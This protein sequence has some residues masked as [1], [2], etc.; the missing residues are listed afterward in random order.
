MLSAD[1]V[2]Q[3][4][5][6]GA[7][8]G[9]VLDRGNASAGSYAFELNDADGVTIANLGVTGGYDGIF[10]GNGSA[11][12]SLQN[13][14][15]FENA[16]SGLDITDAASSAPLI[17]DNVFYGDLDLGAS[18]DQDYGVFTRSLDPVVLR[19]RAY[20]ING[21][22]SYGIYLENA[23][24]NAIVRDNVLFNNSTR[25]LTLFGS[26]FEAT[27]NI[28]FN[29]GTGFYFDDTTAGLTAR[30]HDNVAHN[31][32]TGFELR[33]SAEYYNETA[34][35]NGT[36]FYTPSSAFDGSAHDLTSWRNTTGVNWGGGVLRD[37]RIFGNTGTGLYVTYGVWSLIG[38][39]IYENT[40]GIHSQGYHS[41]N[42]IANN[43]IYDN[44]T[45]G[46]LLEDVQ[47]S[48]GTLFVTN[49]TVMELASD[50]VQITGNSKN[51]QFKNN[52]LWSGGAG[53]YVL[54][55]ANTAQSG[56]SSDYNLLYFTSGA[57]L[58]YWQNDFLSLADW[59]YELG[60]DTHSLNNDPL[61]VDADGADNVRGYQ[62]FAGLKFEYFA[63]GTGSFG[64]S[65]AVT[66]FDGGVDFG[67]TFGS[68]RA[69]TG[70]PGDSQSFRWTGE[71]FLPAAGSYQ[72]WITSQG[73]QRLVI[74]GVNVIDDYGLTTSTGVEQTASYVAAAA[75]WVSIE[76]DVIDPVSGGPTMARLEW[77]TPD[78]AQRRV[79]RAVEAVPGVGERNV[80]RI[81]S[82]P[83]STGADD[84]FHLQSRFGSLKTGGA[85]TNDAAD[86]P[87]VDAGDPT[88]A[89]TGETAPNGGRI[90]L[91]FEGN[92][93]EA[94]HSSAQFI[95]LLSFTGGEKVRQ[96]QASL[97]RWRSTGL[98]P[99]DI[100]FSAN[101][102]S[103]W[104][105]LANDEVNDGIFAWNPAT[106]TL[107]GQLRV[108]DGSVADFNS[109][110]SVFD[111]S[112]ADFTV[113]VAGI[114]YYVND[115]VLA[116]DE[117]SSAAG[118]NANSGTTPSDPMVSLNAVLNVYD[119]GPG[120]II[121][122]DT[123]YYLLPTNVRVTAQ[124]SGVEI[125]GPTSNASAVTSYPGIINADAPL[126]YYRLDETSGTV[127]NDASGNAR[128]GAYVNG[129]LLSQPGAFSG[130]T[131]VRLDGTNDHVD[132]PD[133]FNSF[134]N[135]LT[136][137]F[138][139]YPTS[140]VGYHRFVELGVGQA[141]DNIIAY[142]RSTTNDLSFVVYTGATAGTEVTA[143]GVLELNRWQHFAITM[144]ATGS[145]RIYKNGL[146]V[147]SG[148]T[149]V[150]RDVLRTN[151]FIG[152]S[153]WAVDPYYAG[154]VDEVAIYDKTLSADRIASRYGIATAQGATL[155]R[156]NVVVGRYAVE[157]AAA[158]NVTL[159]NLGMTGGEWGFVANDADGLRLFTSRAFNNAT[160]GFYVN[161]DVL[162]VLVSGNEA[163]GTTDSS[164]TDQDTGFQLRGDRMTILGNRAYK[165][166]VQLG[167]GI[168]V[169]SA[170]ELVFHDNLAYNNV[171][172]IT[173]TT[174][175]ADIYDNDARDND[176]GFYVGDSNANERT[177]VHDNF[178]HDNDVQGFY[179]D[180]NVEVYDNTAMLNDG[181]GF[182]INT[183]GDNTVLHDNY[184][185]RNGNGIHAR[186]GSVIHNRAVGNTGAGIVTTYIGVFISAN[187]VYGNVRGIEVSNF[188]G[189][190][191]V[192]GNL[193]Y[194]NTNSGIYVR[195]AATSG[196]PGVRI[197]N[198]TV[199]H[200]VGSAVKFENNGNNMK[201][202]N[203]VIYINGG[204][205]I[206]VIGNVTGF[207][208]NYNDIFPA[209][210]AANV[211]KW[212]AQP[213]SAT[214]AAWQAAS[215][216]DANS[217]AVDPL[218]IDINGGDNIFGWEQPDPFSQFADFGQDDNFHLRRGSPV[219]DAAD[220]EVA[221]ALD[222]DGIARSDDL[223]TLNTG[224]G[225][226]RFYDLGAYEFVGSSNDITPPTVTALLPVGMVDGVLS[227]ARFSSI[228]VRFNE[229]LDAVSARSLS[230]YSLIEAG[231]DGV[232]GNGN[233]VVIQITSIGYTAGELEARLNLAAPI[234]SG[235][236]RLTLI[237]RVTDAIVDQAG[238]ALDGDSNGTA[239]GDFVRSFQIDQ[240]A[241]GVVS[242][243]PSGS[244]AT[245]PTQ[246]VVV[247]SENLLLNAA[248]VTNLGSYGLT[249]SLDEVFGNGDDVNESARLTVVNYV[250]GTKT[251]TLTLSGAL[252]AQRYQLVVRS[253]ITDQAGNELA[254]GVSYVA[255]LGV[256]TPVLATIG[257]KTITDGATLTFTATATDPD[258][259]PVTFSLGAG[260]PAGA[261]I[262]AGGVFTWTPG[263]AQAGTVY[264]VRVI[265]TDNDAPA[266]TDS[267]I[268]A[269]NVTFNPPPVLSSITVNDG[270][271]QRS[272]VNA[273]VLQFSE[274]VSASLT[275]ADVKL[276][277]LTGSVDIAAANMALTYDPV[278]N[279]ATI[280]FPGLPSQKLPDG[281][282][283][284]TVLKAGVTDAGSKPLATDGA[285][286]FHVLTGD[287]NGDATTNDRDLYLVW[288]NLLKPA[289]ARN[290]NEDL[291]G[292]GQ[293]TSADVDVVRSNYLVALAAPLMAAS[294]DVNADG[295]TNDFDAYSVFQELLKP[296]GLR[297]LRFDLT[298]DG[299]VTTADLELVKAG[300][301]QG[302]PA[303]AVFSAA[304]EAVAVKVAA[305]VQTESTTLE[306]PVPSAS[307]TVPVESAALG[308]F[309]DVSD[310]TTARSSVQG[311]AASLAGL[312][313]RSDSMSAVKPLR[314]SSR[315]AGVTTVSWI[316][317]ESISS[318]ASVFSEQRASVLDLHRSHVSLLADGT[319]GPI[320]KLVAR[321]Q[322]SAAQPDVRHKR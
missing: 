258:G 195:A 157:L 265:V 131:G 257:G 240:A 214:L 146:L 114:I 64:G 8:R 93:A 24:S 164:A 148:Q 115:K 147:G 141:S 306:Q 46:I 270:N 28:A 216:E 126:L 315:A 106:F 234:A 280:T 255:D 310:V 97:I 102:G 261:S 135:G 222:A 305:A 172:G 197:I 116:G 27:G 304:S 50:A 80:L 217:R 95:Q 21:S 213:N 210:P 13:S 59:R 151:N 74:G 34:H 90:N 31:N 272:R 316:I 162:D 279:R 275:L 239:G 287:A 145:T 200:E 12:F 171:N 188:T 233:D 40:T 120:D 9:A 17:T 311:N 65:P 133:G 71:I 68:F 101:S 111:V 174:S 179:F 33:G 198:N 212:L 63:N 121:K 201:L 32:T 176:R 290:L 18:H 22:S 23:G 67:S 252:P 36:G 79:V 274:N 128:H 263:A 175:Q 119:L 321:Q 308:H 236:Y 127:A 7:K 60:F 170:E 250:A 83:V 76:Y 25:G 118:D 149:S 75:G 109:P 132:L 183:G 244:V 293:L 130:S 152:R 138:W 123:G 309:A 134:P 317:A 296:A 117:Y 223:G 2:A 241:P 69:F 48:S 62:D 283:E 99:V 278:T 192:Q 85:F 185:Q 264:N 153:N 284:L 11:N 189:A 259:G 91:G 196:T 42:T 291:T 156:S 281:R 320:L 3:H 271:I 268:I 248:T 73:P 160:G 237:S 187:S 207:D 224:N 41:N 37:S 251:A 182:Y 194:D 35:D 247:L 58:A 20:H 180:D 108:S 39:R 273:L 129:V 226:Y 47:T 178:S 199:H 72:F 245:G 303:A 4:F 256:G 137:E 168:L 208:S 225:V 262:T 206:E 103:S 209:R 232:L 61:F 298:G 49:N 45:R 269:I 139:A 158:K 159:R 169:D 161:T 154:S 6:T 230:L 105:L 299:Q 277:Y 43:L 107:H 100:W 205:G 56:F 294:S 89:F 314:A 110:T 66:L 112:D 140:T 246:F 94:S 181:D 96:G 26:S 295:I 228:L 193:V 136:L 253:T 124:D 86:S 301:L 104:T 98:G 125:V 166:G 220:S 144:D 113:G 190:T 14:R 38:N 30:T 249:S 288:Q 19:N 82:T 122:V 300:Y 77:S 186:T 307:A 254:N 142:R 70:Q 318:L 78:L 177:R 313:H 218:F 84:N 260:A 229:P 1:R 10:V 167:E 202:F 150:P 211:G 266:Q 44:R 5:N 231:P 203:N 173:I 51:V 285:L 87:A 163:Y 322:R 16:S 55:V 302:A 204:L 143:S 297:D 292:D 88:S 227:N 81:Q 286:S 53:R 267:E 319:T 155:D 29:N 289:G 52:I 92:T 191:L 219:V 242:V 312:E 276:R 215:T 235:L 243:T 165:V 282:Y 54:N 238:N 57:K 221:P 15:V 184:A